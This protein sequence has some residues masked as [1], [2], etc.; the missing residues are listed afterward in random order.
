MEAARIASSSSGRS[1]PKQ[2]F[3]RIVSEKRNG[4]WLTRET[5]FLSSP[6]GISPTSL[7]ARK[8]VPGGT[9]YSRRSREKSVLFPLPVCPTSPTISPFRREKVI[10]RSASPRSCPS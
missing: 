1:C 2:M 9:G 6:R 4:S 7:P 10:P 5:V 8:T 3:E